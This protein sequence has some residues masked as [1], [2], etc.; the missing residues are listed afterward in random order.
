MPLP[1][2]QSVGNMASHDDA[3]PVHKTAKTRLSTG[4]GDA[5]DVP[6]APLHPSS[7]RL[8]TRS[9]NALIAQGHP[10]ATRGLGG[11]D[12]DSSLTN[13]D[14][15]PPVC[16]SSPQND[17]ATSVES[18][19]PDTQ[20][21][22]TKRKDAPTGEPDIS[23]QNVANA[24]LEG[25]DGPDNRPSEE[26]TEGGT[27]RPNGWGFEL[28][29][30]PDADEDTDEDEEED[31]QGPGPATQWRQV[32]NQIFA[33]WEG[34]VRQL[35]N[36]ELRLNA[37]T[38]AAV[39]VLAKAEIGSAFIRFTGPGDIF[40][41]VALETDPNSRGNPCTLNEG[42]RDLLYKVLRCP[43]VKRDWE[44]LLFLSV[45]S[46]LITKDL[47]AKM[48]AHSA[49]DPLSTPPLLKL[50]R[51]CK[52]KEIKLENEL[53][54]ERENEQWLSG[55][56]L[57]ECQRRLDHLHSSWESGED[58]IKIRND[59][60]DHTIKGDLSQEEI[61]KMSDEMW[62]KVEDH[63]W[64][65]IIYD[66]AKLTVTARTML[67]RNQ[68]EKP[69]MGMGLG[70]KAW[71]LAEKFKT[72]IQAELV[73]GASDEHLDQA[74][75]MNTIQ[76]RWWR[77][78]GSKMLMTGNEEEAEEIKMA[79][80]SKKLG[81]L[82]G[83]DASSR[84][85]FNQLRM[86]MVLDIQPALWVFE[87]LDH[88]WA[89]EML[90]PSGA[91]LLTRFWLNVRTLI[92]IMNVKGEEGL[93]DAENWIITHD[94][95][96]ANGYSDVSKHYMALHVKTE[97]KQA[98]KFGNIFAKEFAKFCEEMCLFLDTENKE[99]TVLLRKVFDVWGKYMSDVGLEDHQRI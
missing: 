60:K 18:G 51:K 9:R 54:L 39:E 30:E 92:N 6:V 79:H 95:L 15:V 84:L 24:E 47:Q 85:F 73:A 69:A 38:A 26:N 42:H 44:S 52:N 37:D 14:P 72:E 33:G 48:K 31:V 29:P 76:E 35:R 12:M 2:K 23:C 78:I 13:P 90:H 10:L 96:T 32:V 43:N 63:T 74:A 16:P 34:S 64:R 27:S 62:E 61:S 19:A 83:N 1:N 4:G 88:S 45:P 87:S 57:V 28:S 36:Q 21:A 86:D 8:A 97:D 98:N 25:V 91:P 11:N 67:V 81:D 77:E 58:I 93:T 71:W 50:I 56:E 46:H 20:P 68:Y 70:E 49:T 59:I 89:I 5:R 75:A 99:H 65:C 94:K 80:K 22:P 82:A 53:W 3:G 66:S 41:V 55:E 40:G 7:T 17:A